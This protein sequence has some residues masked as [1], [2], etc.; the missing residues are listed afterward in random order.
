[1]PS[2]WINEMLQITCNVQHLKSQLPA[3]SVKLIELLLLSSAHSVQLTY[4]DWIEISRG[5]QS[6]CCVEIK[7]G[8]KDMKIKSLTHDVAIDFIASYCKAQASSDPSST[9]SWGFQHLLRCSCLAGEISALRCFS[10]E[11]F[12]H[13]PL[14]LCCLIWQIFYHWHHD[15]QNCFTWPLGLWWQWLQMMKGHFW[16][17]LWGLD[18]LWS[19]GSVWCRAT[20]VGTHG[21]GSGCE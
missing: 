16:W 4:C 19:L 8:S 13:W 10:L 7:E 17:P 15:N 11:G 3:V 21:R 20:I 1:M 6:T 5:R 12:P 9:G 14:N 18:V 2:I